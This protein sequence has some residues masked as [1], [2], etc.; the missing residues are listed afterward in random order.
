MIAQEEEDIKRKPYAF[1][2]GSFMNAMLC[3][4]FDI[5]FVKGVVKRF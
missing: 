4:R 3:T 5:W 1:T 2:V